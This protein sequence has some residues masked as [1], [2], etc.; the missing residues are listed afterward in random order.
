QFDSLD[1]VLATVIDFDPGEDEWL[2]PAKD[3]NYNGIPDT[4][5]VDAGTSPDTNYDKIP[6]DCQCKQPDWN[7]CESELLGGWGG[8][9]FD[10]DHN[11]A[12]GGHT[13]AAKVS[14]NA[15]DD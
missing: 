1:I 5:D 14:A 2:I 6:D 4:C 11:V 7:V 12:R 3:C 8:I 15:G 13:D 10:A 9:G